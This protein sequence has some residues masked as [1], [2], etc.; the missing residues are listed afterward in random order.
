MSR[1]IL[2]CRKCSKEYWIDLTS[3]EKWYHNGIL[4]INMS[5]DNLCENNK[6]CDGCMK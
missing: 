5:L 2:S 3:D 1:V 4:Q 6:L